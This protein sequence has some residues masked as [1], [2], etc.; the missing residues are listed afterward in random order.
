MVRQMRENSLQAMH[1]RYESVS[2]KDTILAE[3]NRYIPA[4]VFVER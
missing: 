3:I 4:F 2:A 1:T